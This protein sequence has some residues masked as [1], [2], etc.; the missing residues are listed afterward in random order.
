[1][2]SNNALIPIAYYLYK[3]GLPHN[4][5]QASKYNDDRNSVFKWLIAS[6]LKRTFSGQPDNVLRPIRQIITNENSDKNTD[7]PLIKITSSLRAGTKSINF[8]DDEIDNL[9]SYKYGQSYTFS[10]LAILYPSLDF[11]NMFH[12]DHIFPKKLFTRNRLLK[13]GVPSNKIDTYLDYY[14][15]LGN[16]QLLEGVQNQEK[17]GKDFKKWLSDTY[18]GKS[19]RKDFMRKHLIPD[20]DLSLHNFEEFFTEREKLLVNAFKPLL[21]I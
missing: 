19:D 20:V 21:K 13:R 17:S 5:P 15:Y 6:L 11:N 8:N 16:L 4:Y 1:M 9:T 12:I 7:F 18:S 2:T 10:T 3:I 14:N